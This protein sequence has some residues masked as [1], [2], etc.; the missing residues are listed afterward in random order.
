M[1]ADIGRHKT[2]TTSA[3]LK[4]SWKQKRL[5]ATFDGPSLLASLASVRSPVPPDT[6]VTSN[7]P[8]PRLLSSLADGYGDEA[9]ASDVGAGSGFNGADSGSGVGVTDSG[10]GV[11]VTDSGGGVGVTYSGGG[12]GVTDSDSAVGVTDSG[13]GVGV[14]DSGGGVG[15]TYSGGGVGGAGSGLHATTP[16]KRHPKDNY[17][18]MTLSSSSSDVEDASAL[19]IPPPPPTPNSSPFVSKAASFTTMTGA[20]IHTHR[21]LAFA[22]VCH[23]LL[24]CDERLHSLIRLKTDP[25]LAFVTSVLSSAF[26]SDRHRYRRST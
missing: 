1:V 18:A 22:R 4:K 5:S 16:V 23:D 24:C 6:R 2:P 7:V 20:Q 26:C 12:V 8:K 21:E 3:E 13:S 25:A 10:S 15:V 11:G 14:T 9:A 17:D 19:D